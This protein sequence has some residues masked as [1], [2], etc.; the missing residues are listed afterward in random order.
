MYYYMDNTKLTID[1]TLNATCNL[2]NGARVAQREMLV[3]A[4]STRLKLIQFQEIRLSVTV[5]CTVSIGR[6]HNR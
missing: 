6:I 1:L 2:L 4:R 5:S 3:T